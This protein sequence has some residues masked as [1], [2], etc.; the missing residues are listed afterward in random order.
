MKILDACMNSGLAF[1][2]E[3]R[4]LNSTLDFLAYDEDRVFMFFQGW[5]RGEE[6]VPHIDFVKVYAPLIQTSLT[7]WG[8]KDKPQYTISS[9]SSAQEQRAFELDRESI[10]LN[11]EAYLQALSRLQD[12]E[13][14][15][16]GFV[17]WREMAEGRPAKTALEVYKQR[18]E[19]RREVM[20]ALLTDPDRNIIDAIALDEHGFAE[21]LQE[22]GWLT[23]IAADWE[24]YSDLTRPPLSVFTTQIGGFKPPQSILELTDIRVT[25]H[26]GDLASL[27]FSVA[28]AT[29]G[30]L[31]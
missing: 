10:D 15:E 31:S 30:S 24:A 22:H 28:S 9:L 13:F 25:E 5:W 19:G 16:M 21:V 8:F 27:V 11:K 4:D 2:D 14:P 20:T 17:A 23:H 7:T 1:Y 29:V 18:Y 26:E 12:E 3:A 6:L